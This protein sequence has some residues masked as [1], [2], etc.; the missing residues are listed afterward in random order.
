M[1]ARTRD[2]LV[3]KPVKKCFNL[4]REQFQNLYSR[5][6]SFL[7]RAKPA[8]RVAGSQ[9]LLTKGSH[10]ETHETDL[11]VFGFIPDQKAHW[12]N[13]EL[14]AAI[15][16]VSAAAALAAHMPEERDDSLQNAL[17][18][19]WQLSSNNPGKSNSWYLVRC[20]GFIRDRLKQGISVDSP[21]RRRLGCSLGEEGQKEDIP[22]LVEKTDPAQLVAIFDALKEICVRLDNRE[23]VVLQLLLDGNGTR[24]IAKSLH[25]SPSAVSNVNRRIRSVARQIGLCPRTSPEKRSKKRI[26]PCTLGLPNSIYK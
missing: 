4:K 14:L 9:E 17:L 22:E 26:I 19:Y 15:G 25:L 2:F 23:N 20:R 6:S 10:M 24:E 16:K 11:T 12:L 3:G 18:C 7:D 13:T 21:K 1:E 8:P 5:L